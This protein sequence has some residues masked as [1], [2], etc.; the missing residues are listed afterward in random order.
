MHGFFTEAIDEGQLWYV[1]KDAVFTELKIRLEAFGDWES[2]AEFHSKLIW[3]TWGNCTSFGLY[4]VDLDRAI[5]DWFVD[6][7]NFG[8]YKWPSGPEFAGFQPSQLVATTLAVLLGGVDA[9][10]KIRHRFDSPAIAMLENETEEEHQCRQGLGLM[11]ANSSG[12]RFPVALFNDQSFLHFLKI[13]EEGCWTSDS[14]FSVA[15]NKDITLRSDS[16]RLCLQ[17]ICDRWNACI[18]CADSLEHERSL[19]L[20]LGQLT[21][22]VSESIDAMLVEELPPSTHAIWQSALERIIAGLSTQVREIRNSAA[23]TRKQ[24]KISRRLQTAPDGK[25]QFAAAHDRSESLCL[26][27]WSGVHQRLRSLQAEFHRAVGR[28]PTAILAPWLRRLRRLPGLKSLSPKPLCALLDRER[29]LKI[30]TDAPL[31][32]NTACLPSKWLETSLSNHLDDFEIVE[33]IYGYYQLVVQHQQ[34][35][36]E[37]L[38]GL[39]SDRW[40]QA[41]K[42]VR[43]QRPP[44]SEWQWESLLIRSPVAYPKFVPRWFSFAKSNDRGGIEMKRMDLWCQFIGITNE[45]LINFLRD[46]NWIDQAT[47]SRLVKRW[48]QLSSDTC[49]VSPILYQAN[50]MGKAVQEFSR[51]NRASVACHVNQLKNLSHKAFNPQLFYERFAQSLKELDHDSEV[52]YHWPF[53]VAFQHGKRLFRGYCEG[54]YELREL[55]INMATFAIHDTMPGHVFISFTDFGDKDFDAIYLFGHRESLAKLIDF[56][57]LDR[58]TKVFWPDPNEWNDYQPGQF[59]DWALQNLDEWKRGEFSFD[60]NDETG[61]SSW[62][63]VDAETL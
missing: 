57:Q 41:Y 55:M 12:N 52:Y 37:A 30:L 62:Y 54:W 28:V 31:A 21:S 45:K 49:T 5:S 26:E 32:A 4:D 20:A 29:L 25:P 17:K 50:V 47:A 63:G 18:A 7:I 35:E 44:G 11:T 8:H 19:E 9:W 51:I 58:M 23:I 27:R 6:Q 1:H 36:A 40:R 46:E 39:T 53:L 38:R 2:S 16:E 48:C 3:D 56:I 22:V 60:E 34:F 59:R 33:K 24:S 42:Q 43:T 15:D 13:G 14:A 10:L 61:C